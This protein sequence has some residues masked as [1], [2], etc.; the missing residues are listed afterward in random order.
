M[1]SAFQLSTME[2]MLRTDDIESLFRP[3][4]SARGLPGHV[5]NSEAFALEEHTRLFAKT[6]T[7]AGFA[8]EIPDPGSVMPRKVAGVPLLFTRTRSSE[9]KCFHNVCTHRGSLLVDGQARDL[10]TLRCRY[11]GWTFDLEG[12]LRLTPH[13]GGHNRANT[14]GLDRSCLG[15]K[16]VRME[17]WHDWLFVNIDGLAEPF[18]D[19]ARPFMTQVAEYDLSQATWALTLDYDI[20]GNW[21][22]V[23]ENYL[24]TLHL[25]FVHTVLAEVAPFEQHEVVADGACLGTIIDVGLPAAWSDATALPRWPGI[26]AANRTA[27]NLALFPNFKF[28]VGPD[29]ACSMVEFPDGA[30]RSR[31]RWDFY[32]HGDGATAGRYDDAR[33]SVIEFFDRTNVEDFRAVEGVH[34]G[35]MS[36]AM[37][38]A[39]FN[40]IWEGGVHHFQKLVAHYMSGRSRNSEIRQ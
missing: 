13:W 12:A 33:R 36:P 21:K 5:Y 4:A 9:V 7:F 10:K 38:G 34:Q 2:A 15:L 31:Q 37:D 8:H 32:F 17:R 22:L 25:N 11:H 20:A 40:G 19:Y 30:G 23:T 39:R 18:H 3:T 27:K 29:H 26:D 16:P 28:M 24:E 14:D 6:W 35:H 1:A